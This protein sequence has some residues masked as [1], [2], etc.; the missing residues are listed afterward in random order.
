MYFWNRWTWIHGIFLFWV[1]FYFGRNLLNELVRSWVEDHRS[2]FFSPDISVCLFW[3]WYELGVDFDG[4]SLI[5]IWMGWLCKG[6][7]FF[8]QTIFFFVC[9]WWS[10]GGWNKIILLL[11][12]ELAGEGDESWSWLVKLERDESTR[13]KIIPSFWR[14][15]FNPSQA[16]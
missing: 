10:C 4:L 12:M 5:S 2:A 9:G 15:L 14:G 8:F 1:C 13:D 6:V 7:G 3:L 11:M 16:G